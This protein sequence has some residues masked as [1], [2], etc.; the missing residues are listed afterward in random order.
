M[1][2]IFRIL[3]SIFLLCGYASKAQVNVL[4]PEVF[5]KM[6]QTNTQAVIVDLRNEQD[7]YRARIKKA[8]NIDYRS[9]DFEEIFK[10]IIP[11]DKTVLLYCASG[12]TS[13]EAAQFISD[14]GYKKIHVLKDGF[15]GWTTSSKPYISGQ[16]N[17][18][19]VAAFTSKNVETAVISNEKLL[20]YLYTS[21]CSFCKKMDP[22]IKEFTHDK[23]VKLLKIDIEKNENIA[24]YFDTNETPTFILYQYGKQIWK[25]RGEQSEKQMNAAFARLNDE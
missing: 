13:Q 12:Q 11:K 25:S 4:V 3:I 2:P 5:L 21:H 15:T 22:M 9:E 6:S 18:Q 1:K 14:L 20:V 24:E 23:Q 17:T 16:S 10:S 7:F 8:I 19:P